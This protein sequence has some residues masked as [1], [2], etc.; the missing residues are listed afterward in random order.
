MEEALRL[1]REL[2]AM[3]PVA[4]EQLGRLLDMLQQS[5]VPQVTLY[6]PSSSS[7][8]WWMMRRAYV[9]T[10]RTD[11]HDFVWTWIPQTGL[12]LYDRQGEHPVHFEQ[13]DPEADLFTCDQLDEGAT[14]MRP[15]ER[16]RMSR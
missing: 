16:E 4:E 6:Y 8:G 11:A 7:D 2:G 10:K 13:W 1:F 15:D 14:N 3:T 9:F 12:M 5:T